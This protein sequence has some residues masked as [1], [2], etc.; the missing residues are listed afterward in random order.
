MRQL[1]YNPTITER[2]LKTKQEQDEKFT[3]Q[4]HPNFFIPDFFHE[5]ADIWTTYLSYLEKMHSCECWDQ[6]GGEHSYEIINHN[7]GLTKCTYTAFGVMLFEDDEPQDIDVEIE[8]YI[9]ESPPMSQYNNY[10]QTQ[11]VFVA[12]KVYEQYKMI[13]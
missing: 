7:T 3:Y 8:G 4:G 6:D 11:Y 12:T 10:S 1:D 9:V 13:I 2:V 5:P